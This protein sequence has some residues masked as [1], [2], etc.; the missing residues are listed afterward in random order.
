MS[1]NLINL[2]NVSDVSVTSELYITF[3]G[4]LLKTSNRNTEYLD[5]FYMTEFLQEKNTKY[6][7][8]CYF[9]NL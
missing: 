7:F 4:M 5:I 6:I 8:L 1:W 2:I 9:L 3:R